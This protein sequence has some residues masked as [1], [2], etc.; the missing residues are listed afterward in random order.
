MISVK[1][2]ILRI[3]LEFDEILINLEFANLKIP[4]H[5]PGHKLQ[6][7]TPIHFTMFEN[8]ESVKTWRVT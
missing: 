5:C 6:A 8:T 4:R 3:N 7:S 1:I 2:L